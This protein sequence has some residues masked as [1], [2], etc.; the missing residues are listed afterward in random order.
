[1][2]VTALACLLM[3][4]ALMSPPERPGESPEPVLYLVS[5]TTAVRSEARVGAPVI[6]RLRE[7]DIVSGREWIPGWLELDVSHPRG[8]EGGWILLDRINVV[9]GPLDRVRYRIFRAQ[10]TNWPKAVKLEVARGRI[11]PGF[12]G[13]QVQLALGDPLQK[14]LRRS[15]DNVAEEWTYADQRVIFS[16]TG[17]ARIEAAS[18]R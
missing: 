11:R 8:L 15:G 4:P 7:F 13:L 3:I 18:S 9:N 16:S 12:T 2:L 14:N 6:G 1:M 17:V 10:Q 5:G